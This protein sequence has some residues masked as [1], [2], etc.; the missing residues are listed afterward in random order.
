MDVPEIDITELAVLQASDVP[1]IDVREPDEYTAAHVPGATLIPLATVPDNVDR[2][3]VDGT[4][5][6]ICARGGRSL[7]AAEF[8][9]AQGV[10]AVN[11]AGGTL[12]WVDA[13]HSVTTGMEP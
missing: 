10:D 8:L 12:A 2:V 3:P 11:V 7:R 6:V 5:Y 9:R 1:L 4:V 13:G